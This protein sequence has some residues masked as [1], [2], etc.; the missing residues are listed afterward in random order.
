MNGRGGKA[1]RRGMGGRE[2]VS[3]HE[4]HE[5]E[6]RDA[7]QAESGGLRDL[8]REGRR[9]R[10]KGWGDGWTQSSEAAKEFLPLHKSALRYRMKECM[11]F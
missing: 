5:R 4:S 2:C 11:E 3:G 9:A 7:T 1:A 10:G 8:R 6:S